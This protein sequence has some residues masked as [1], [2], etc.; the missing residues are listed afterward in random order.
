[1]TSLFNENVFYSPF[2]KYKDKNRDKISNIFLYYPIFVHIQSCNK[3]F[4]YLYLLVTLY[5]E[6]SKKILIL[7]NKSYDTEC[8]TSS[9][10]QNL[11]LILSL[12]D[13]GFRVDLCSDPYLALQSLHNDIY[14]MIII[15]MK[16]TKTES[17]N[18][19]NKFKNID[20]KIRICFLNN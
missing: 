20:K 7:D 15:L 6:F 9:S 18:L 4:K 10:N 19:Y 8:N 2:S 3:R 5:Q 17:F 16:L 14:C 12:E 1:M 13:N 11:S